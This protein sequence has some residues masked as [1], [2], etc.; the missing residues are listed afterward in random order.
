M[1][2]EMPFNDYPNLIKIRDSKSDH[3]QT[4]NYPDG[5]S[6]IKLHMHKLN[7]K[8]PVHIRCSIKNFKE[9][10][11]L[12]CATE[13]LHKNDYTLCILDFVYL[14]GIRSDRAF[15]AGMPNYLVDVLLPIISSIRCS[16][17]QI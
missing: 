13:A 17:I 4:I 14:F 6:N 8:K 1:K 15:E 2:I 7:I 10:E 5:Q 3:F 11:V 12:L 16:E 9:L